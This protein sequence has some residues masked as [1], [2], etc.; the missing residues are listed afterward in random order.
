MNYEQLNQLCIGCFSRLDTANITCPHCGYDE[1]SQTVPPYQLPPRTILAGKYMIGK[2]LGE[3]GFGITYIAYD[4]NLDTVVAVKEYYPTGLVTRSTTESMT[5]RSYSGE[6]ADFF[7]KGRDR[8][9]DEA[10]R[11]ARFRNLPGIVMVNDFLVE[12]GTAYIV[13][14]FV[15]G[16]T[17]K[18]YLAQKGG[19]LPPE[20]VFEMMA[21]MFDSLAQIHKSGI[22]HRD[23]SPD[24]IMITPDGSVKLLDFGAAREFDEDGNKSLSV[25]LKHGYAPSEQYTTKGQQGPYTDVYGLSATIYKILTGVTPE[26]AMDRMYDDTL[27]PISNYGI[28]LPTQKEAALRKGLAVRQSDRFQTVS[29]LYT[30][31]YISE[32]IDLNTQDKNTANSKVPENYK[33]EDP[34][35]LKNTLPLSNIT[36]NKRKPVLFTTLI[37]ITTIAIVLTVWILSRDNTP[38]VE[39]WLSS[40][41][42]YL[43]ARNYEQAIVSFTKVIEIEPGNSRGYTG[44]AEA[45]LGL[46]DPDSAEDIL[47]QGLKILPYDLFILNMLKYLSNHRDSI[48]NDDDNQIIDETEP[49][50]IPP[51]DDDSLPITPQPHE[52]INDKWKE[53]FYEEIISALSYSS[54]GTWDNHDWNSYYPVELY[55][56]MLIDLNFDGVPELVS[57]GDGSGADNL[58]TR[59]FTIVN[60]RVNMIFNGGTCG[61]LDEMNTSMFDWHFYRK[62]SDN[63]LACFFFSGGDGGGEFGGD[64]LLTNSS[65]RM[66]SNF[67]TDAKIAELLT[68]Y[69]FDTWEESWFFN[70]IEVNE[71]DYLR[72][73]NNLLDGYENVPYSPHILQIMTW[74]ESIV[75][76]E[77]DIWDF[78]N[79]YSGIE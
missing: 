60:N 72:L 34:A 18:S 56:F 67:Y 32:S 6:Y 78:I 75:V 63:S 19:K 16:Q 70:R 54:A 59:I 28:N 74:G 46:D 22:I 4:L 5:V 41:E 52:P 55:F 38:T 77:D 42:S 39:D 3:G 49:I 10:K 65:S 73:Q 26:N 31:L 8:F 1:K 9:V 58:S 47:Q 61:F 21:P 71:I 12:N 76:T 35:S 27:D 45:Y 51:I 44:A 37:V 64:I 2:V 66:D 40:G 11:L 25:M 13:M 33:N 57:F 24:N 48:Y 69:D 29:D 17:L 62:T 36:R 7:K 50:I 15:H 14:E 53:L 68:I 30:A 23:I 79:N 20:Q 43:I